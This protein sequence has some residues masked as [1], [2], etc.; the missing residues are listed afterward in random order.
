MWRIWRAKW[1]AAKVQTAKYLL[2]K[3]LGCFVQR[4]RGIEAGL[5][6]AP[7]NRV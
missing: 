7:R 1:P 4:H 5:E 2:P 3:A 6:A